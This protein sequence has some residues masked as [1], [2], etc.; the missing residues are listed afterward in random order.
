MELL[1]G[2]IVITILVA[3]LIIATIFYMQ[4]NDRKEKV[5]CEKMLMDVFEMQIKQPEL[6][7]VYDAV[8]NS[9][10]PEMIEQ[11]ELKKEPFVIYVLSVF[12]LVVDYYFGRSLFAAKDPVMKEAWVNTV[13]NFYRD[14]TDGRNIYLS[15][16]D[17]FNARFQKF[18]DELMMRIES[19]G[20]I[21]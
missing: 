11:Y 2:C 3:S 9:A 5:Q 12:D 17:E 1:V 4:K 15:H 13:K 21:Q 18:S 6:S 8:K 14:S 20:G 7:L 10:T 19:E 16:R